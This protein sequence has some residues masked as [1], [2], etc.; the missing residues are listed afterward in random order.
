MIKRTFLALLLALLSCICLVSCADDGVPDGMK[1]VA[2]ENAMF[3][4]YVPE[5]WVSQ[6]EGG[7][8]GAVS[9]MAEGCN[10]NATTDMRDEIMDVPTYWAEK[11]MPEYEATFTDLVLDD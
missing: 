1:N 7:V 3:L 10:V 11:C 4:L 9:P 5:S 6:S 2:P 8:V